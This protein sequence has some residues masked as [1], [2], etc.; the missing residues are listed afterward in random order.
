M[1]RRVTKMIA[2]N[3]QVELSIEQI[4]KVT[5]DIVKRMS[6]ICEKIGVNYYVAYGSL[7]G[8]V[9]HKG[10]IPWDDD[11]DVVMLRDDYEKF[12]D[13]CIHHQDEIKPY[14]LLIHII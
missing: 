9:R 13:Y 7:I 11:F 1:R 2:D 12:C 14:K 8:A 5:L 4:H 3:N 6:D 10:F